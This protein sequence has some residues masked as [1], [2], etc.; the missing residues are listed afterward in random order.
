MF[1]K[2]IEIDSDNFSAWYN[3]ACAYSLK[4]DKENMLK[5]LV[6][7]IELDPDFKEKAKRDEDFKNFWDDEDFKKIVNQI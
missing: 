3:K 6:K 2:A 1:D 7:A 4:R 5:N